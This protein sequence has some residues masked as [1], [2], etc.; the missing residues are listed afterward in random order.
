MSIRVLIF[1]DEQPA[2]VQTARLL[3]QYNPEI[4]IVKTIDTVFR[5]IEWLKKNIA[6]DLILMDIQLADGTCFE[7]FDHIKINSPIIFITAYDEYA[8]TAFKVNSIDYLLKPLYFE[9]LA[10]ALDKFESI[11]NKLDN[12]FDI[13]IDEQIT[14]LSESNLNQYRKR[15]LIHIADKYHIVYVKDILYFYIEENSVFLT[16]VNGK[17]YALDYTLDKVAKLLDPDDFFRINRRFIISL[18]S[19]EKMNSFSQYRIKL[20][21][22]KCADEDIV[23][24]RKRHADFKNWIEQ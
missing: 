19:I 5:G 6:I 8:I 18:N 21:L 7:I 17:I 11:N 13:K 24:S 12:G 23:V 3:H 16:D 1:E 14:S 9:D 10:Y 4:E 15:F 22:K 2:A 20:K